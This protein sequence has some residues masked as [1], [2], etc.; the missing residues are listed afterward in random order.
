MSYID[1]FL[2]NDTLAIAKKLN[3]KV[4]VETGTQTADTIREISPF[5]EKIYSCEIN[6]IYFDETGRYKNL[7]EE[8]IQ[9]YGEKIKIIKQNSPDALKVFFE[10]IGHDNIILYLDAHWGEY[11]PLPD[12]L[13]VCAS[14]EYKPVI[15]IHDFYM[16]YGEKD[17]K[18]G[19]KFGYDDQRYSIEYLRKYIDK[20]YGVGGYFFTTN[21]NSTINRGVGFFIPKNK[22]IDIPKIDYEDE[23]E[24]KFI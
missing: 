5:F 15:I 16:G 4:F 6:D 7:S 13:K 10:E 18:I 23:E 20:I 9:K 24:I 1:K 19:G 2:L 21:S 12:E 11:W 14:F 8:F 17:P 22:L 3:I